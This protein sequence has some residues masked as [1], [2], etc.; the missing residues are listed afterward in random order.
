MAAHTWAWARRPRITNAPAAA[1]VPGQ[2]AAENN[3]AAQRRRDAPRGLQDVQDGAVEESLLQHSK[4]PTGEKG[5]GV[6]GDGVASR[7]Y[8]RAGAAL[9]GRPCGLGHTHLGAATAT[10]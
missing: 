4:A 10:P 5:R 1:C 3:V 9:H 7:K 6:R 8:G 2:P